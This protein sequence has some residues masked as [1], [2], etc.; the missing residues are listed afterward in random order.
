MRMTLGYDNID[1]GAGEGLLIVNK[2][3]EVFIE[4]QLLMRN[5]D[6]K[7]SLAVCDIFTCKQDLFNVME[8]YFQHDITLRK[9]KNN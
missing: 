7:M 9:T 5:R 8:Y 4:G 1:Y 2:M 3:V 6:G